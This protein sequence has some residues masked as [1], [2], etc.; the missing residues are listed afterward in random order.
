MKSYRFR[1]NALI[2]A[3]ITLLLGNTCFSQDTIQY[4]IL[5]RYDSTNWITVS[6]E[7][8]PQSISSDYPITHSPSR[9]DSIF[10]NENLELISAKPN[11]ENHDE[12]YSMACALWEL[13]KLSDAESMFL[14]IVNSQEPFY[15]DTYYHSSDI[16]GDTSINTY[17]YGSFT[18][19]Y[20]NYA[21]RYLAKIYIEQKKFKQAYMYA[22]L[23]DRKYTVQYNCG[24]GY[25]WYRG[26]I[27]GLYGHC[28]EGL[29]MHDSIINL[30]LPDYYAHASGMLIRAIRAKYAQAE[31]NENLRIADSSIICVVDTVK[32]LMI[33]TENYGEPNETTREI[34]YTSGI[35]SMTLFGRQVILQQPQLEEGQV[36]TREMYVKQFKESEFYRS[37][38]G[39][40]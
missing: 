35:A 17:G 8:F 4:T 21:C 25:M 31:I 6:M 16:P 2:P 10:Y 40:E 5:P 22:Q 15:S 24:T 33:V 28:Y 3:I 14:N 23:A 27:N 38:I 13:G 30:F 12:Y 34:W 9:E 36:V 26:E 1:A 18:S 39:P 37:L 11:Q 20:K 19:N 32:S 7:Y 29:G